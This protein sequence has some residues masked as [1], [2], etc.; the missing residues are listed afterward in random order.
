VYL[1]EEINRAY[2]FD[3]IVGR[4]PAIQQ[5]LAR[6]TQV[7]P[8]STTVLLLGETG[9]GKEL[10]ARANH[11]RSPRRPSPLI[12]VNC[13]ALPPTLIES[14][15]FGHEKGAFT[16]ATTAKVGRFELAHGGTLF[17]DEIGDLPLDLQPKLL[18]VLQAGEFQRV[19]GIRTVKVDVRILAAT[20]RDLSRALAEGRFRE[21]LY[22][23]LGVLPILVPPLRSRREDIPL[24]VWAIIERRRAELG[25]RVERVP[26]SVMEALLGYAW[27]GNVRELENLIERAL[28]SVARAHAALGRAL[29]DDGRRNGRT[30]RGARRQ[31]GARRLS[32]RAR[33][34][35]LEDRW[36][37][38]RSR[39]AGPAPEHPA[40]PDAEARYPTSRRPI[41]GAVGLPGG[42]LEVPE[43]LH[44]RAPRCDV[45]RRRGLMHREYCL[46]VS[47]PQGR[48]I[49]L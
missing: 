36:G 40:R 35:R 22:Y 9:T 2:G 29:P 38:A 23:R 8:M 1:R 20:N 32:A 26:E 28:I 24:L 44:E 4:S 33:T 15:L 17:L 43:I 49:P 14:E 21:D 6:V 47:T 12:T 5:V 45:V 19:G 16:G 27:P 10:L 46:E 48:N 34:L 13:A 30:I 11:H 42:D 7:A 37:G 41:R 31:G 18:R 25:R 39:G 3:D